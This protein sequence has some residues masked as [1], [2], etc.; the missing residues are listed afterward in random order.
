MWIPRWPTLAGTEKTNVR[1]LERWGSLTGLTVWHSLAVFVRII[2]RIIK[3]E[4]LFI[5]CL[6]QH[7]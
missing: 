1:D 3:I 5:T 4:L 7:Y 2:T 6:S